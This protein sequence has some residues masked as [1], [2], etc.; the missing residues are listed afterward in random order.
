M[1]E[2]GRNQPCPCNSGKKYKFCHGRFAGFPGPLPDPLP[3]FNAV[4]FIRQQQQGKGRPIV[5]FKTA[6][7]QVVAV[8]N[9]VHWSTKCK[10]FLDFL[11]D[12][13]KGKLGPDWTKAEAAKT[14][15][16]QHPLMQW[17]LQLFEYQ[18]AT[19]KSPDQVTQAPMIGVIAA[20][21]GTA[22]AL[23]L[24][25]HN[26]ELQ[27]RLLKR[28]KD[29]GQFQGA[30]YELLVASVLIRAGFK[31]TLEDETDGKNKHCEFAAISGMT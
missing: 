12:Y 4:E 31:L 11:M 10:T 2:V 13:M 6:Q 3:A 1:A 14:S 20:Y 26:V 9:T 27:E 21:L 28:L 8:G 7:H 5:A 15:E 18:K 19:I 23:Y 22:Y 29:I 25:E 30:Y 16:Q 24:L 17:A